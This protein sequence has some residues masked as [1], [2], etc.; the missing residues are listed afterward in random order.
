MT[1]TWAVGILAKHRGM[2]ERLR[3]EAMQNRGRSSVLVSTSSLRALVND[4]L[5][6]YMETL[7]SLP[8]LDAVVHEVLRLYPAAPTP[9]RLARTETDTVIGRN[10]RSMDSLVVKKGTSIQI[11]KTLER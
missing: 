6:A 7:N 3:E 4:T 9:F 8:H 1:L 11:G 5:P 10:G 2:E